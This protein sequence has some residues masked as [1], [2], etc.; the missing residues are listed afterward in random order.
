MQNLDNATLDQNTDWSIPADVAATVILPAGYKDEDKLYRALAWLRENQPLGIARVDGY[1]PIWLVTRHADVLAIERQVNLFHNM[2]DNP[3]LNTRVSDEFLRANNG[4]TCR[5]VAALSFMDPPEHGIYRQ[6][7]AAYF[8]NANI[9]TLADGI[10]VIAKGAVSTLL[11]GPRT[12]DFV[13]DFALRYPLRVIMSVFGMPLED[14]PRMLR[15][16]QEFFGANDPEERRGDV[17]VT[18]DMAARQFHTVLQDFYA[19][20][21]KFTADRRQAPRDDLMSLIANYKIDG[22]YLTDFMVNGYYVTIATAGHDTT[23]STISA[24]MLALIEH[25]EIFTKVK[26]EPT[27]I[28]GLI[29]EALR[30]GSPVRHFMRTATADT[31]LRNRQIKKG[32]RLML[33]YPSAN[34]DEDVFKNPTD[35]D[36]SRRPNKHVAFGSGPHVCL[37]Q[38]LAKLEMKILLEELLPHLDGVQLAGR[39]K[40]VETNFVGGLKSL[41][42]SFAAH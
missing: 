41:P 9:Q 17:S 32:D 6:V 11:E 20:F 26:A 21:G 19:Y 16:T 23:S 34:R 14:E 28:P 10:R 12:I 30:W 29:E 1:D 22:E 18:P 27:A 40:Y 33:C 35:F 13:K 36:I 5:A 38:Q 37:G 7:A 15:L 8:S 42:I 25:P 24:A 2:D 31:Q 3:I 39:P 4:G